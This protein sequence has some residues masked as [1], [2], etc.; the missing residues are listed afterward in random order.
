MLGSRIIQPTATLHDSG[1][2]CEA[3]LVEQGRLLGGMQVG[4]FCSALTVTQ[5]I[6]EQQKGAS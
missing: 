5:V 1:I 4:V 3:T 2:G 6:H